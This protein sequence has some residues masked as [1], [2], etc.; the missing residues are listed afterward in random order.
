MK[1]QT[2]YRIIAYTVT[3]INI[4]LMTLICCVIG[5]YNTSLI[6]RWVCLTIPSAVLGACIWF[7]QSPLNDK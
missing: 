3:I 7:I 2:Q 4:I 6:V 5:S 1:T